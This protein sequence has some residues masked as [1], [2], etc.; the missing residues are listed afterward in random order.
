MSSE[1]L[2]VES[3]SE[4]SSGSESDV[5]SVEPSSRR[6]DIV[7]D[8]LKHMAGPVML[9]TKLSDTVLKCIDGMNRL[10]HEANGL[11][12]QMQGSDSSVCVQYEERLLDMESQVIAL[13][14]KH[15]ERFVNIP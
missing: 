14:C 8:L 6:L 13:S 9:A 2:T 12:K 11:K 1:C 15:D 3:S 5:S 4:E 7:E 10:K